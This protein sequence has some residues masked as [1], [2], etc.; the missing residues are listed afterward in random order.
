M[1]FSASRMAKTLSSCSKGSGSWL[2]PP[3]ALPRVASRN[4]RPLSTTSRSSGRARGVTPLTSS[5]TSL[6]S[7]GSQRSF[8]GQRRLAPRTLWMP[9]RSTSPFPVRTSTCSVSI[10]LSDSSTV[11]AGS[12]FF[13]WTRASGYPRAARAHSS[14]TNDPTKPCNARRRAGGG[15]G[16]AF[17]R[18][19]PQRGHRA[20]EER[21]LESHEAHRQ[22]QEV[23]NPGGSCPQRLCLGHASGAGRHQKRIHGSWRVLGSGFEPPRPR[24]C[25]R[26]GSCGGGPAG[27]LLP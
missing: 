8:S 21:M 26:P 25:R 13:T 10:F 4:S 2:G 1:H 16:K 15:R 6:C 11:T 18:R 5:K 27:L 20:R 22:H 9:E 12:K 24:G 23:R 7:P 19:V 3:R 14:F 17:G